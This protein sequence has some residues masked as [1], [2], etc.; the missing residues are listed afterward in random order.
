VCD[1]ITLDLVPYVTRDLE[2]V[3]R[4]IRLDENLTERVA[5]ITGS[6][7]NIGGSSARALAAAVAS[8]VLGDI[9]IAGAERVAGDI[10]AH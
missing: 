3:G 1:G 10:V 6:G 4:D 9:N 5:I 2:S 7:A 8:V